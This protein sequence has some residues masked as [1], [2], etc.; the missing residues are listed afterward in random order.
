MEPKEYI[1]SGW[2]L[3]EV[4]L[5]VTYTS[6]FALSFIDNSQ[7]YAIKSLQSCIVLFTFVKFIFYLRIYPK[8]SF[9]VQMLI[10][11]F[12]DMSSFMQ[13]FA[14]VI[15]FFSIF[16]GILVDDLS[17]YEGI[18][19]VGFFAI[20]LRTSVGDYDFDSYVSNSN[21]DVL[22]WLV[23]LL[24]MVVGNVIFMNFIIAVVG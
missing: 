11:V 15:G 16:L 10:N 9:L 8:F 6:Y 23:W 20:A 12:S 5:H 1:S 22:T 21:Y 13:L 24:I 4:F 18:G 14:F 17:K 3:F 2:N 19:P 7:L